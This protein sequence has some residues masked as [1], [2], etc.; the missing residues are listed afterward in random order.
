M[1][2]G[3]ITPAGL[4]GSVAQAIQGL[5]GGI[6]VPVIAKPFA[7]NSW[8]WTYTG[9][10]VAVNT[11]VVVAAAA[12]ATLCRFLIGLQLK[13]V[14]AVPTEVVV[15][16]GS[17]VLWRG[18]LPASMINVDG[19]EFPIPLCASPNTAVNFQCITAGANVYLSAQGY[20]G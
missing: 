19:L 12:G 1:S 7:S 4:A 15:K 5:N 8:I 6:P 9:P 11:D 17:V 13:N 14:G 20:T 2:F 18:F 10:P 3:S 16:D